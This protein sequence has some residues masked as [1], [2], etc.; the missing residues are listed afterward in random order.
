MKKQIAIL[1]VVAMALSL[2][3]ACSG[4][5]NEKNTPDITTI[6]TTRIYSDKDIQITLTDI[7]TTVMGVEL[8]VKI[9]NASRNNIILTTNNFVVNGITISGGCFIEIAA[10]EE[11]VDTMYLYSSSLKS[12][13][14][15][16]VATIRG[17]DCTLTDSDTFEVLDAFTF[18]LVTSV[19]ADYQQPIHKD[20]EVLLDSGGFQV[21]SQ[22]FTHD[23]Y[24]DVTRLLL[25]NKSTRALIVQAKDVKVNGKPVTGRLSDAVYPDSVRYSDLGLD[26]SDVQNG[27]IETISFKLLIIDKASNIPL[28]ETKELV[29]SA[30]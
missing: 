14:I 1:L 29:I 5:S 18:D 23:V 26:S 3:S 19:G 6:E 25:V 28:M 10:S 22:P 8:A 21:I 15:T 2:L 4:S 13:G 12:A 16:S 30:K 9:E 11:V 17:M 27:S 24:G 7:N 20:G